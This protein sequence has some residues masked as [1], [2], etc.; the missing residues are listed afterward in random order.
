VGSEEVTDELTLVGIAVVGAGR[1][2]RLHL[3]ALE[4]GASIEVAAVTEPFAAHVRR[5]PPTATRSMR[6][7]AVPQR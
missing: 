7:G 4:R 3:R 5:L 6:P 1:M 2:R